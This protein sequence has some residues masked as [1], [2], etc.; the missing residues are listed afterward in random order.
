M[1]KGTKIAIIVGIIILVIVA[2]IA[3]FVIRD[4][5]QEEKLNEELNSLADLLDEFPI[6]YDKVNEKINQTI[7]SGNY[8][9]VEKSYK[10][11]SS[12][13]VASLKKLD[14]AIDEDTLSN[15]LTAS[16]IEKDGPNFEKT[17]AYLENS[18]KTL[19]EVSSEMDSYFS[20]EK[21][22]SYINDKNLDD[23]YIDIYKKYAIDDSTSDKED[24]SKTLNQLKDI[25]NKE[26]S[27][28]DFLIK[29]KNSW[30][31]EDDTLVFY[32]KT[33]SDH[34]EKLTNELNNI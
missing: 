30:K 34:Y 13:I 5:K 8:Y 31:L 2:L 17:K 1:K 23:Y 29:N 7:T 19:D 32:S 25:L 21:V 9:K 20:E 10:D 22:L 16:N 11:F 3:F 33:L 14:D 24:I 12:D 6:N 18:K 26:E 28:I 15:M 27:V 4:L